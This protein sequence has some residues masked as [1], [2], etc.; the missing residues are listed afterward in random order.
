MSAPTLR[1]TRRAGRRGIATAAAAAGL[2]LATSASAA[3]ITS[4]AVAFLPG[5][6]TDVLVDTGTT[7]RVRTRTLEVLSSDPTSFTTRYAML[8]GTDTGQ[9]AP[10]T[11][12]TESFT[13][14]YQ[15][16]L[17]ILA[18]AGEVWQ[19]LLSASR[20]GALTI[21]NDGN[22]SAS[23]TLGAVTSSVSG[24]TLAGSLDL[25]AVGTTSNAGAPTTS[26]N[27]P[28]AQT[29]AAMLTGVGTGAVQTVT[30]RFTWTASTTSTRQGNN[31][32]EAAVRM[33][34]TSIAA[35]FT[36]D[37]YPGVGGRTLSADG[38]FVSAVLVPEP[39]T[40]LLCCLGLTGLAWSSRRRG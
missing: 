6:N 15:I 14:D 28:F 1:P 19:L 27:T 22:G 32:D 31:S 11:S 12:I 23:A 5:N 21:V 38:H 17:G 8:V 3:T 9:I 29:A 33:G 39:A 20:A 34:H 16:T 4:L 26:P 13:A 40:M 7:T 2:L 24:G 25:A 10:A 36:A 18:P 30:L 37:D 35:S